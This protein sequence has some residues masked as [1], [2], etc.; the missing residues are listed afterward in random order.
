MP[1]CIEI[2]LMESLRHIESHNSIS[3]ISL[4]QS[5]VPPMIFYMSQRVYETIYCSS[6]RA[7]IEKYSIA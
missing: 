4:Q 7:G 2:L 1:Y 3:Q 5:P 6:L